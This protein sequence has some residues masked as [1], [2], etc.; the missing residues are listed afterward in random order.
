LAA[1]KEQYPSARSRAWWEAV[2]D[3]HSPAPDWT[4][5]TVLWRLHKDDK[6]LG[7]VAEQLLAV[8]KISEPILDRLARS[9]K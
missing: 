8:A 4:E 2:I 5:P 9:K 6:F 7:E 1:I 3:L